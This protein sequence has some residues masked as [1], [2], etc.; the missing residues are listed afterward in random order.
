MAKELW[1]VVNADMIIL[2][3]IFINK[4]FYPTFVY[5]KYYIVSKEII[6]EEYSKKEYEL[7]ILNNKNYF[8]IDKLKEMKK[9][10]AE[11]TS[12]SVKMAL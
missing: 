11:L 12:K 1:F 10:C 4:K 9:Y 7:K 3:S 2:N 5:N 6:R 8:K